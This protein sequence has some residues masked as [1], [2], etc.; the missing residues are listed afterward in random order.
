MMRS[1]ETHAGELELEFPSNKT[2]PQSERS[3]VTPV[4]YGTRRKAVFCNGQETERGV[5]TQRLTC[6]TRRGNEI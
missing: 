2:H 6:A 1:T 4:S 5:R 3:E